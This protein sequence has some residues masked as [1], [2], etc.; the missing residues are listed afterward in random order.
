MLDPLCGY[1]VLAEA[2]VSAPASAPRAVNFGPDPASF[3]PVSGVV[4]A[5]S[6]R[7]GGRPGWVA[8]PGT[9]PPEARALTLSSQRAR[10]ALGWAPRLDLAQGLAWTADWYLAHGAGEDMMQYSRRQL[11]DYRRLA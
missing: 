2:L 11:A 9:H 5:F 6:S 8:A 4:E 7:F 1:L 3:S 10:A